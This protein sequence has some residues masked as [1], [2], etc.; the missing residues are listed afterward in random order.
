MIYYILSAIVVILLILA[1]TKFEIRKEI[2]LEAA[3][4]EVWRVVTTFSEY[5]QWNSQLSY[6]DGAV[7]PGGRLHL[8]LAVEGTAPYAFYANISH[9]EVGKRFAWIARTG[10]PRVFDGEHFFE[11]HDLG[12]GRTR[13]VNREEYRGL[14]SQIIRQLPMMKVAPS[15][16]EKMNQ[17]LK[18]FVEAKKSLH[19]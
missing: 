6:L 12:Q 11:L 19:S 4:M 14:L 13:L 2:D 17:E 3:P 15:G 18:A 7:Q 10:F 1:F 9:W 5:G 8:R 16:F